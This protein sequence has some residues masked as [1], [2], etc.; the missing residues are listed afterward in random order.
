M[1][2]SLKLPIKVSAFCLGLLLSCEL[3]GT[4]HWVLNDSVNVTETVVMPAFFWRF[5]LGDSN[6]GPKVVLATD[7][8]IPMPML[9]RGFFIQSHPKTITRRE[10]RVP[11][12]PWHHRHHRVHWSI[13]WLPSVLNFCLADKLRSPNYQANVA[14]ASLGK[15]IASVIPMTVTESQPITP[16][17][18]K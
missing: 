9:H 16:A 10:A 1:P 4:G 6:P 14:T 12:L 13:Q 3:G 8:L 11:R 17:C 2:A 7:T 5:L 15:S 18:L